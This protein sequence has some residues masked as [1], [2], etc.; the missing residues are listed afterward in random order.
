MSGANAQAFQVKIR[1]R[2]PHEPEI[3][4]HVPPELVL[5]PNY[6]EQ[7]DLT[8]P[9]STTAHV[10]QE[11]PPI[12]YT[13]RPRPGLFDGAWVVTR[14]E[15]IRNVYQN[16][17]LY[18]TQGAAG[19][20]RL[21]GETFPMIPLGIDPPEH[22]K[23][24][25]MLNPFFSP[26]AIDELEG[27]IRATINEL[28][29]G[30]ADKGAC[31]A[32]YD[33][34]RLY[35]V[36]V[37]LN[38]MGFPQSMLEQ[39]LQWEYALL[40]SGGNPERIKWGIGSAI[41]WLRG[42]V[43]ETRRNPGKSLTSYIVTAKIDGRPLTQD[44]IMGTVTFLWIGG[45]D[46]VAATTALMF[47]RLAL[48]PALQQQL[49]D[50][51]ELVPGAI[52]EFMRMQP[53]VNSNRLVIRDHEIRGVKIKK[54]DYIQCYNSAGNFDPLEFPNPRETHFDREPN[55]HFTLAGGPHRCLGSHLARREMR[56]AL[57]EFLRRVPPFRLAPGADRK[58]F[59]GLIAA[60]RVPVT[61]DVPTR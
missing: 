34:G 13:P 21:V 9:F 31:D 53:L 28:I 5:E 46:T 12:F 11:M 44:E 20:N 1:G 3:P 27:S 33:F 43:E 57:G 38:L 49:R 55:R 51:P 18:S 39:F 19:F 35:P 56:I 26:K 45:L 16:A 22:A 29:D 40:H 30:F 41:A 36:R 4:A 17:E 50:R 25:N 54:G 58:A 37:F 2:L 14:Y 61:W 6:E 48:E 15:D 52:E 42:F 10:Y 60:P 8:D 32:A 47:R 23:Y 59:P 24:R 7:N